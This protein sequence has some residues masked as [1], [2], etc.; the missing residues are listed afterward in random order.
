MLK[1]H[2]PSAAAA[3]PDSKR[4]KDSKG[5]SCGFDSERSGAYDLFMSA[6]VGQAKKLWTEAELE[7]LPEDGFTHEMV[8]Q[9][10][11]TIGSTVVFARV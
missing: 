2:R 4:S 6:A 9:E 8:D 7:A 10:L 3:G 5:T 1:S 11:V